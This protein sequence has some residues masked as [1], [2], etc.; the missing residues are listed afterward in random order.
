MSQ[1]LF[2]LLNVSLVLCINTF[3]WGFCR[4]K[5]PRT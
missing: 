3:H 1:V 5:H 2:W 4:S